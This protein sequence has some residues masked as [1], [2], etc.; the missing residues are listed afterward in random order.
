MRP[1]FR[2]CTANHSISRLRLALN[3]SC[4]ANTTAT[5]FREEQMQHYGLTSRA[6]FAK[7]V[8]QK[9]VVDPLDS[10]GQTS[11]VKTL[12]F[13]QSEDLTVPSVFQDELTERLRAVKMIKILSIVFMF[14]RHIKEVLRHPVTPINNW[15][16]DSNDFF[17]ALQ[18]QNTDAHSCESRFN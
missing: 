9:L 7:L 10:A 4:I 8:R 18:L 14:N 2:I 16:R 6:E 11:H 3:G 15:D 1:L 13:T 12:V 17:R 5:A